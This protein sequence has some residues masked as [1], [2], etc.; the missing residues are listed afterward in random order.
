MF[1]NYSTCFLHY[2]QDPVD[3]CRPARTTRE[4][5]SCSMARSKAPGWRSGDFPAAIRW[6]RAASIR[7]PG[8]YAAA[9]SLEKRVLLA[10]ALSFIVLYGY[11]AL[12]PPPKPSPAGAS[13]SA[14]SASPSPSQQPGESKPQQP[15]TP[16]MAEAPA[17]PQPVALVGD[18]AERDIVVETPAVHAVF[19][20]RGAVLKSWVLKQ[21]KDD[22][23]RSSRSHPT[24]RHRRAEALFADHGGRPDL[25]HDAHGAVQAEHGVAERHGRAAPSCRSNIVTRLALSPEGLHLPGRSAYIVGFTAT[26]RTTGP[27]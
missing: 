6:D 16:A 24:D 14:P 19:T 3:S 2:L 13:S 11:Q 26:L 21:Y 20:T 22:R 1:R 18:T 5:R 15:G 7:C 27:R 12:F 17:G 10:V 4:T 8:Q 25:D 23:R 9:E